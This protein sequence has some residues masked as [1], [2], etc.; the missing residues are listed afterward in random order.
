[1]ATDTS[2]L[3][4]DTLII[5]AGPAGLTAA[6]Y[7]ARAGLK[8]AVIERLAPGGQMALTE[9][10]ENYPGFNQST[11]GYELS[12]VMEAQATQF[13]AETIYDAV[14]SVDFTT[15]PKKLFL[16]SG[17]ELLARTVI[18]ATGVRPAKL[19][20][21]GEEE[22]SGSGISYCATCDGNFFRDKDVCVV[23]GGNTAVADAIYLSRICHKVSIIVRRD[24]LRATAIYNIK[25][26]EFDNVEIIWNTTVE[27]VIGRDFVVTGIKVKN[28]ITGEEHTIDCA[29]LFVAIGTVPNVEF[30]GDAVE[31]DATG[32][33]V[34]NSV[35]ETSV[36]GV[37]AAGDIRS[38]K[39]R[40]ITTAVA[41]GANAAEDAAEHLIQ[42]E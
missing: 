26:R 7:A 23:G 12:Q 34:T 4:Y 2:A 25:L 40:Q 6:M 18:I 21:P 28:A 17:K 16:A 11:S 29:A 41:D 13:G 9:H 31:R 15:C 38:K 32:H 33:I 36:P 10:L 39:L 24:V 27:E 35:G 42:H 1:M 8:C 5:G 14:L 3:V 22:F 37:Y 30:L 19:Q 20:I